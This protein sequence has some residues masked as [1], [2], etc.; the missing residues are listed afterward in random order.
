MARYELWLDESGDFKDENE[1]GKRKLKGSLVGGILMRK[2]MVGKIQYQCIL[3]KEKFHATELSN[4]DKKGYV[5]PALEALK[6]RYGARQV[7]F[8]NTQYEEEKNNRQLYLRMISEGLLQLMLRLNAIEEDVQLDVLIARRQDVDAPNP[9]Q[10]LIVSNE[11]I[12]AIRRCMEQ[13]KK[14]HK[15]ILNSASSLSYN[16]D[17]ANRVQKLQF[18]DF[19]CN[20]RLTRDSAAFSEVK[21]RLNRLYED[22]YIFSLSEINS[23]NYIRRCLTQ[24]MISDA[25][26]ELYTTQDRLDRKKNLDLIFEKMKNWSYRTSKS[27]IRQC[28]TDIIALIAQEDDY[29]IGEGILKDINQELVGR[30]LKQGK[31]F[32]EFQFVILINLADMYLRE[33][34]ILAGREVLEECKVVHKGMGDSLENLL[35][36]YQLQEKLALYEI[37]SFQYEKAE[38]TMELAVHSFKHIMNAVRSDANLSQRFDSIR[39]EYLGDALCMQ[40][41][42]MMF[43]QRKS[44]QLYGEMC[45]LSDLAMTQYPAN[46]GELERHR[47]YRGHIEMEKGNYKKA[48]WRLMQAKTYEG[49]TEPTAKNIKRFLD[50]VAESEVHISCQYYLMYYVLIMHAAGYAG[51]GLANVMHQALLSQKKLYAIIEPTEESGEFQNKVNL[52]PIKRKKKGIQYHPMEIIYWKYGSFLHLYHDERNRKKSRDYL[53]KAE[54]MC[55]AYENYLTMRITGLGVGAELIQVLYEDDKRREAEQRKRELKKQLEKIVELDID[56]GTLTYVNALSEEY[57]KG[58]YLNM[59]ELVAY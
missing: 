50:M 19:A 29:E 1:K 30:L 40:I 14:E 43:L 26:I 34:D 58:N 35:S 44:P 12:H 42:A 17:I 8:E 16:I 36:Y 5:L 45:R 11:Y 32:G 33:G 51:D 25:L 38:K 55:F 46:E 15:I 2:D 6:E 28:G 23:E 3:E 31:N 59:A 18:A 48:L 4:S 20:T 22:A 7:F 57:D 27:Q 52:E 47:Q 10:R 9:N 54:T 41:Y 39:S 21:D 13:K 24:G 56:E 37:D 49:Y 53:R